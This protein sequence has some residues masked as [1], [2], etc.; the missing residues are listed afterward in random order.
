VEGEWRSPLE[1]LGLKDPVA[2]TIRRIKRNY[3]D[4][5]KK[6]ERDKKKYLRCC[7]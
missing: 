5:R 4:F 1:D 3:S 6:V 7:G 2:E